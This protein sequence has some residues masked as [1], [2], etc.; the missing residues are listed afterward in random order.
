MPRTKRPF[1][2]PD[3][4]LPADEASL[5]R[6]QALYGQYCALCH[7]GGGGSEGA[8]PNLHRATNI[9]HRSFEDIVIGGSREAEGMPSYEGLL[10]SE[11]VRLIHA[12]ILS[13]ARASID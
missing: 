6:G 7:G 11:D 2:A 12:Y 1:N 4:G 13:R 3:L 5:E 10:T 9:V 8:M